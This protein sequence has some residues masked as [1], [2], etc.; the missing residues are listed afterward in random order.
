MTAASLTGVKV[1]VRVFWLVLPAASVTLYVNFSS[2]LAVIAWM[3]AVLG[4]RV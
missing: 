4:D 2:T 1:K 3:V